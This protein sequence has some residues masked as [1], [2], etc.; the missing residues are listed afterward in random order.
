M[1]YNPVAEKKFGNAQEHFS[2]CSTEEMHSIMI[3]SLIR[4]SV[5]EE[6]LLPIMLLIGKSK[7]S[8]VRM[9]DYLKQ[10]KPSE[11]DIIQMAISLDGAV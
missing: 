7:E 4:F 5:R 1:G 3:R 11:D 8:M 6:M 9:M 10:E 2:N